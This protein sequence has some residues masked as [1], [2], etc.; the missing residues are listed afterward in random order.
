MAI[1][2]ADDADFISF[3]NKE[4]P[5]LWLG[6]VAE[7]DGALVGFGTVLW[8]DWGHA[9]GFIDR[10][11]PVS[12]FTMHRSVLRMLEVLKAVGEPALYVGCDD[13]V[14]KAAAWLR[15][16]GFAPIEGTPHTWRKE[17]CPA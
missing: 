8:D 15:R 4:P 2:V 6:F 13:T 3:Y 5:L 11:E 14:P 16:L 12:A 9:L 17:L 1:R 7:R 10:R